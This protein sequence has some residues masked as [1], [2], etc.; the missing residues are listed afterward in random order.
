MP[1]SSTWQN[2]CRWEFQDGHNGQ[3]EARGGGGHLG[4]GVYDLDD[5]DIDE[6]FIEESSAME[7]R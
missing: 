6:N 5:E 7:F 2:L 4:G 1:E 3:G